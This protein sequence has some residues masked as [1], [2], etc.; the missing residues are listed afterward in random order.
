[1]ASK[2]VTGRL[3][4]SR[5]VEQAGAVN[6]EEIAAALE[7]L[8]TPVLAPGEV[9]P[10]L[11]LLVQ[12]FVRTLGELGR[13]M[14][15]ADG[16]NVAA[17]A[18]NIAPRRRRDEAAT[19]LREVLLRVRGACESLFHAGAVAELFGLRGELAAD[20]AQLHRQGE[21]VYT[22]L[23]SSN[24]TLPDTRLRGLVVDPAALAD[25]LQPSLEAL[26]AALEEVAHYQ[27]LSEVALAKK[28]RAITEYDAAF[29]AVANLFSALLGA[30][31]MQ[32]LARRVRPS[33]RRRGRTIDDPDE[34]QPPEESEEPEVPSP[35]AVSAPEAPT[36][37]EGPAGPAGPIARS[38]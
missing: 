18:R 10:N 34:P 13:R 20:P 4:S 8:L 7:R 25:E 11:L 16:L 38:A 17:Q 37:P 28:N 14:K 23:R 26:G 24:L 5:L 32:E 31:E 27:R 33:N 21:E 15:E 30:G 22:A 29:A 6:A 36:G 3:K 19:T 35:P 12:L 2:L 1:V 9:L